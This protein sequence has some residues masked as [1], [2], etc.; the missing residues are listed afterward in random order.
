MFICRSITIKRTNMKTNF[1]NQFKSLQALEKC[2][3]TQKKCEEFLVKKRWGGRPTCPYCG[4]E[5]V[6]SRKNGRYLCAECHRSFS[7]LVGTIFQNT[8]LPLLTWF[9]AIYIIVNAKQGIS[10]SQLSVLFGV[11]QKTAWYILHKIRLLLRDPED[12]QDLESRSDFVEKSPKALLVKS[13]CRI[14]S[15]IT[16]FVLPGSRI[17]EDTIICYQSLLDS[18][19]KEYGVEDPYP[20]HLED[21]VIHGRRIVDYFWIQLKRMVM[22]VYHFFSAL[23]LHQYVY[24]AVFRKQYMKLCNGERFQVVFKRVEQV[25]TYSMIRSPK[26]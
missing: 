15:K 18:E 21:K 8:K 6:Y 16:K 1:L 24:E 22:G 10:S 25:Y 26:Q 9:K 7:V 19:R 20:L 3:R 11:T 17:F 23:H 4:C 5:K 13:P 12:D 14:H 2:F